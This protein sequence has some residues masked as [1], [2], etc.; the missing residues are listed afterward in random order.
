MTASEIVE[1]FL[2]YGE[3]DPN[4]RQFNV[5]SAHYDLHRMCDDIRKMIE[6]D[7]NCEFAVLYIKEKY[8]NLLN[9]CSVKVL[10]LVSGAKSFQEEFTM[11][12]MLTS[13][14]VASVE[15]NILNAVSDFVVMATGKQQ[16]GKRNI[17]Q[18]RATLADAVTSVIGELGKCK[19]NLFLRGGELKPVSSICKTLQVFDTIAECLCTIEKAQDALYVCFI[20]QGGTADGFFGFF[21]KNNGN[22]LAVHEKVNEAYPGAH[23]VSRNGRWMDAKATGIFPY[24]LISGSDFDYKGYA[25]KLTIEDSG[26]QLFEMPAEDYLPLILAVIL[27]NNKYAYRETDAMPTTY[28]DSMLPH[29]LVS[30]GEQGEAIVAVSDSLV[31]AENAKYTI[32]YTSEDILSAKPAARFNWRGNNIGPRGAFPEKENLFVKLYGDGFHL[33]ADDLLKTN[34]ALL[35]PGDVNL[36]AHV[37]EFIGSADMMDMTA[38]W[39]GRKQLANYIRDK[40][41]DEYLAFGGAKAVLEWWNKAVSERKDEI[42]RMCVETWLAVQ[43][44]SRKKYGSLSVHTSDP[45]NY[46]F[47]A[48]CKQ[49][50]TEEGFYYY[51]KFS[52]FNETDREG[53]RY[54]CV[55]GTKASMCFVFKPWTWEDI[56]EITGIKAIPKCIVGYQRSGHHGVGNSILEQTDDVAG[57][58]TVFEDNEQRVNRRLWKE[59]NWNS[60]VFHN[61]QAK[62]PPAETIKIN[63]ENDPAMVNFMFDISFSKRGWAKVLKEYKEKNRKEN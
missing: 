38:Y 14:D 20:R 29:N 9:N 43:N 26:R 1:K 16:I 12:K 37:P 33:N 51:N 45:L 34:S 42:I 10:D 17:E 53:K 58:G 35:L 25:K 40:I 24:N 28:V 4:E 7:P 32:P 23:A 19:V 61:R 55:D 22:I 15:D 54:C 44:G 57:V 21:W 2:K 31:A 8:R 50:K 6:F 60:Y 13:D 36:D 52:P 48:E 3:Y 56:I 46:V 5:L 18:E 30:E 41:L 39:Q 11:W 63:R 27:I 62:R 47:C 49:G 59:S